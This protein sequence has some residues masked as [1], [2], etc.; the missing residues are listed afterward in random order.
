[1]GTEGSVWRASLESTETRK[2]NGFAKLADLFAFLEKEVFEA[3]QG[4]G[5]SGASGKGGE[6]NG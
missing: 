2:R 4:Q 1:V 6:I 5:T 3:A